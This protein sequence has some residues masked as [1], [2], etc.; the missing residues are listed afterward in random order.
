MVHKSVERPYDWVSSD[1]HLIQRRSLEELEGNLE[2]AT[3]AAAY[4][5]IVKAQLTAKLADSPI[6]VLDVGCG[7]GRETIRFPNAIGVDL[8][9]QYL[10]TARNYTPHDYVLADAHYLPFKSET[11]DLVCSSEAVEHLSH[12]QKAIGEMIRT[13]AKGGRLIIQTPNKTWTLGKM[14][15]KEFGH[16]RELNRKDLVQM[17]SLS[18]L[19]IRLVTGSTIAYIPTKNRFYWLNFNRA[20]FSIWKMLNRYLPLKWDIIVCAQK[21]Q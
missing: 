9:L 17:L 8:C 12:V 4:S 18:N 16:V 10:K 1:F 7:W 11:F 20:F 2:Q 15:H 19:A 21:S 5:W 13:L 6:L 14:I 3:S